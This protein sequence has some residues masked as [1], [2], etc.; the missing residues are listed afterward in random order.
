MSRLLFWNVTRAKP[1][2]IITTLDHHFVNS[3]RLLFSISICSNLKSTT[4]AT[5]FLNFLPKTLTNDNGGKFTSNERESF[6]KIN[7]ITHT[8]TTL[9]WL[10]ANRQ[11]E[12]INHVIKKSIQA[13]I[14][15]SR[16]GKHELDTLLLSYRNTP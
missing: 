14:N 12:R 11:V 8:R 9:L 16:N 10:E 3:S 7:G 6:P 5:I 2:W 1:R 15:K 13:A 4:S